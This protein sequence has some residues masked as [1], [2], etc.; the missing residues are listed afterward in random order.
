[1]RMSVVL[2]CLLL[3]VSLCGCSQNVSDV[4]IGVVDPTPWLE[5]DT[6]SVKLRVPALK[7]RLTPKDEPVPAVNLEE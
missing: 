5:V 2:L 6:G 1:M 7:F 4:E 3:T